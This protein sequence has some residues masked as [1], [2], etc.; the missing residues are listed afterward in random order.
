VG[1][2]QIRP[3]RPGDLERLY[4]ICL[5]TGNAG[6]DASELVTDP[7]LFGEVYAAPY[8]RFEPEHALV[9]DDGSGT[10]VGYALGA[11]D[12]R[13]FEARCEAD[14]WPALRQRHPRGSGGNDLDELLISMLHEPHLAD[15]EVLATYPSHLHIDLLPHGQGRGWGRRLMAAMEELL[16]RAGSAGLHLGTSVRNARAIGFY[17]HLGY[18]EI[19]SNGFSIAFARALS[20]AHVAEPSGS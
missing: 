8:V 17:R 1:E 10:A 20:P 15:D 16:A 7:R 11:V 2:L 14:W 13:A 9:V 6:E 3:Y 5:R 12:T 18:R 19:G 4:E